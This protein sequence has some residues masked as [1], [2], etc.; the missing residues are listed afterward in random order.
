MLSK[1]PRSVKWK[2]QDSLKRSL[3]AW[4]KD[5]RL[6]SKGEQFHLR[7]RCREH[8]ARS[9]ALPLPQRP[10]IPRVRGALE[11]PFEIMPIPIW[12]PPARGAEP[13]SSKQKELGRER[14][15]ADG[16]D[17]SLL[18]NAELATD[19]T[20]SILRDSD[21]KRSGALLIEEALALSLQ[22]VASV[23]SC[24]FIRLSLS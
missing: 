2:S 22:G 19:V 4:S 11:P 12:S 17:D 16:D 18:S 15:G 6:K 21:L 8:Q 24:V 23:S 1:K 13:P 10:K 7:L 14:P 20:S 5:P 9:F 3:P